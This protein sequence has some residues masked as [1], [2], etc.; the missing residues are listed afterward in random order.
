[1]ADV[2]FLP[3]PD[4]GAPDDEPVSPGEGPG[5]SRNVLL[6]VGAASAAV[7]IVVVWLAT[8][9]SGSGVTAQPQP[10]VTRT[11][12]V[13]ASPTVPAPV[14]RVTVCYP[15]RQVPR[16]LLRIVRTYLRGAVPIAGG[17]MTCPIFRSTGD[18]TGSERLTVLAGRLAYTVLVYR[19]GAAQPGWSLTG[20]DWADGMVAA[21]SVQSAG[22]NVRIEVTGPQ[23]R[24][25]DTDRLRALAEQ[26]ALGGMP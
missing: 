14:D 8:R 13:T 20:S 16:A 4:G 9:P 12:S 3:S 18:I 22:V 21:L 5:R 2:E 23:E 10:S 1:M 15:V 6:R 11:V 26:L 19:H 17:S 7:V 25:V 24:P